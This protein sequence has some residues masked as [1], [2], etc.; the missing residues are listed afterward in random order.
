MVWVATDTPGRFQLARN[1]QN[2]D[3]IFGA[4]DKDWLWEHGG[5]VT[6]DHKQIELKLHDL[7]GFVGRCDANLF[8]KDSKRPVIV[9]PRVIRWRQSVPG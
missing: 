7:T 1:G 5:T 9:G 2:L 3:H 6:V 8:S 4:Q